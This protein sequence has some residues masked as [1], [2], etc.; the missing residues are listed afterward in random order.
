MENIGITKGVNMSIPGSYPR[1]F[2]KDIQW[3]DEYGVNGWTR[4][5]AIIQD[6]EVVSSEIGG[7]LH[8][9]VLDIDVPAFL[10]S[11]STPGHSH[12]YIDHPMSWW[13]YK[14]L[15]R[16]MAR[17]GILEKGYVR[18][19]IRRRHTAVRVPWLKK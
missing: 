5:P 6:A 14:R 19:S 17:A 15:L 12:L 16:A 2:Y 7:R 10:V 11:S 18:A 1:L 4:K 13:K 3:Q 9:P 8:C